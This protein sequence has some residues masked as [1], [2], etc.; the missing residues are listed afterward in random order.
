MYFPDRGCVHTLLPLYVYAT[1]VNPTLPPNPGNATGR[2][3]AILRAPS[4]Y[5]NSPNARRNSLIGYLFFEN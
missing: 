2:E 3:I 4:K 1:A 5:F